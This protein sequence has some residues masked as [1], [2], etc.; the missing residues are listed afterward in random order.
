MTSSSSKNRVISADTYILTWVEVGAALTNNNI[1]WNYGLATVNFY[2][3]TLALGVASV[4]GT[5]AGFLVCHVINSLCVDCSDLHF[6]EVLTVTS[7]LLEVLTTTELNDMNLF[8]ATLLNDL[9]NNLNGSKIRSAYIYIVAISGQQNFVE[10]NRF[11]NGL[12]DQLEADYIVNRYA[13]LLAAFENNSVHLILQTPIVSNG[14][15]NYD[16]RYSI[17]NAH[18]CNHFLIVWSHIADPNRTF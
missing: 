12:L 13:M 7:A 15:K 11:A 9:A 16:V 5:T 10:F 17:K 6:S 4:A 8:A 14:H 3:K 2:T 18:A 1:A